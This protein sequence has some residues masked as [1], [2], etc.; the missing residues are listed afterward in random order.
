MYY[1]PKVY[2]TEKHKTMIVTDVIVTVYYICI[3]WLR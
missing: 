1:E 2:G 3:R